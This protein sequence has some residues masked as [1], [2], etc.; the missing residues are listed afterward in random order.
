LTCFGANL[1][2]S[3]IVWIV[4]SNSSS[5][6]KKVIYSDNTYI[7]DASRKYSIEIINSIGSNVSNLPE[8]FNMLQTSLIIYDINHQDILNSYECVC[9]IYKKCSNANHAMDNSS[10]V[11][12]KSINNSKYI[13]RI[14]Q[15]YHVIILV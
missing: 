12:I 2:P 3:D 11:L 1:N 6:R 15:I 8:V 14:I 13:L 4:N 7:G 9:N 10:L 5:I